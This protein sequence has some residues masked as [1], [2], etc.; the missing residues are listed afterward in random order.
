MTIQDP[1]VHVQRAVRAYQA[2]LQSF[3]RGDGSYRYDEGP[4]IRSAAQ[5]WPFARGFVATLD[6]AGIGS[7]LPAELDM[8]SLIS[9][10]LQVLER[11]WDPV[12]PRPAYCSD[13]NGPSRRGDRYYDDNA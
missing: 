13:V 3:R 12:G 9:G 6:V 5:L 4:P 2:M 8:D 11:Y 1:D 10:H 7:G